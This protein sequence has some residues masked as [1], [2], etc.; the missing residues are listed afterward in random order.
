MRSKM[1]EMKVT[2]CEQACQLQKMKSGSNL[3]EY[4]LE[5]G[6]NSKKVAKSVAGYHFTDS[7]AKLV[8]EIVKTR[9]DKE[10]KI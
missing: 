7:F 9:V 4:W 10:K 2:A 8:P 3:L 5:I 6:Q 1:S